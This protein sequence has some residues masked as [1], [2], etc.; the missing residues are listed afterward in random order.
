MAH[1]LLSVH[2]SSLRAGIRVVSGIRQCLRSASESERGHR[3]DGRQH[4]LGIEHIGQG[5]PRSRTEN[6]LNWQII[7]VGKCLV[8]EVT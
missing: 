2:S 1:G 8:S 5:K 6:N 3:A 7:V 4:S